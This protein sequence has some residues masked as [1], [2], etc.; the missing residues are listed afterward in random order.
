MT[1]YGYDFTLG[2]NFRVFDPSLCSVDTVMDPK[3][4]PAHAFRHY[5]D[6][7]S[8]IIP[9]NSFALAETLE[10]VT[11]PRNVIAI[12]LGKSTYARCALIANVTPLEP[13]WTGK[14]TIELSNTIPVPSKV[15]AE[16]GII[17][18]IFLLGDDVC[19]VSYADK[20][21]IYQNQKGIEP[22]KVR[23]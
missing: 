16:E 4:P 13:E 1:S 22:S 18:A 21:G 5:E 7:D 11:I 14:I 6:V 10:T 19:E 2:R 17:Q 23:Q 15:Y 3:N 20:G 12:C 8:V 9:P